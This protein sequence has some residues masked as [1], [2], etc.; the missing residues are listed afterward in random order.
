MAYAR[1]SRDCSW[2]VFWHARAGDPEPARENEQLAVWHVSHRAE[3]PLFTYR[4]VVAMLA[5][6]DFG[7][8]PGRTPADD[9]LLRRCFAE[10]VADVEA[11]R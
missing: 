1:Y 2:Y 4:D 5:R 3:G 9:E 11:E 7:R 8:V 6:G 10:F